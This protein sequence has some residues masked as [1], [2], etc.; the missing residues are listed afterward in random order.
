[1]FVAVKT[2]K[3][4][5]KKHL[6]RTGTISRWGNSLGLRIPSEGVRQLRLRD[7]ESVTLEIGGD[8]IVIRRTSPRRK[9]TEAE[10]LAGVTPDKV[11][12][13]VDWGRPV[14]REVL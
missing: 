10:L 3:Q 2:K 8:R 5:S 1:L 14:G 7:G 4:Q 12:G 11:G 13:E 9:W 6:E